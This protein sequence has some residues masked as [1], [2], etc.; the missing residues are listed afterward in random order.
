[1][2]QIAMTGGV[3]NSFPAD[4]YKNVFNGTTNC[5]FVLKSE[6]ANPTAETIAAIPGTVLLTSSPVAVPRQFFGINTGESTASVVGYAN[7]V[8]DVNFGIVRSHDTQKVNWKDIN[9]SNGVFDYTTVDAWA[10]A[11]YSQGRQLLYTVYQTPTWASARPADVGP[12]SNLGWNAEPAN[13]STLA[14]HCTNLAQRM[15]TRGTPIKYWE[16][17]NE[18]NYAIGGLRFYSGTQAKLAEMTRVISQAVKAVDPTALIVSPSVTNLDNVPAAAAPDVAA[19]YFA[20]MMAAS[21]GA[22][23]TM[24]T[25]VDVVGYHTYGS[26]SLLPTRINQI[27]TAAAAAGLGSKPIFDTEVGQNALVTMSDYELYLRTARNLIAQAAAGI[28]CV[29]LYA[30]GGVGIYGYSFESRPAVKQA[31]NS[32]INKLITHGITSAG[33]LSD[34]T[35][36]ALINNQL[37]VY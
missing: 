12:Y 11:H 17:S 2:V 6:L 32:L 15:V 26:D 8:S 7:P 20:A 29:C 25:W 30:L 14:T 24:A 19:T 21:D 3:P 37:E 28:S 27:K 31:L 22:S 33:A 10:T 35:V 4:R 23:G 5:I 34:G 9:P 18:P 13:M 16:V 1:M 36:I